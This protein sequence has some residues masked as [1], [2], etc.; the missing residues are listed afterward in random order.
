MFPI[1]HY[2][3]F[4]KAGFGWLYHTSPCLII[5]LKKFK[6]KIAKAYINLF[7]LLIINL[8]DYVGRPLEP[9]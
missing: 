9:T 5:L 8:L 4:E 3:W 7:K 2:R 6:A 1:I